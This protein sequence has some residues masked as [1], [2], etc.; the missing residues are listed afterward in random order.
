[1]FFVQELLSPYGISFGDKVYEGPIKI[2]E[3]LAE[4]TSGTSITEFPK[5]A[6]NYLVYAKL[7]D[8]GYEFIMDAMKQKVTEPKEDTVPVLALYQNM[9]KADSGRIALYGD[10]SCLDSSHNSNGNHGPVYRFSMTFYCSVLVFIC[11][12]LLLAVVG[13]A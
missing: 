10:S 8:Q 12:R 6:E 11:S 4:F 5:S 2:G 13:N 1:M 9:Y 7:K 3:H